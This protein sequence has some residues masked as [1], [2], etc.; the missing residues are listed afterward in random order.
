MVHN[1]DLAVRDTGRSP[2]GSRPSAQ[3]TGCLLGGEVGDAHGAAVE[4]LPLATIRAQFG[5]RGIQ[6]QAP[7]YGRL[8]A[9]TDDTQLTLFTAEELIRAANRL[10][11]GDRTDRARSLPPRYPTR[12]YARPCHKLGPLPRLVMT[13]DR[14]GH[15]MNDGLVD[16]FRHSTWATRQ[17]LALSQDL[18]EAQ[19]QVTVPGT[20][21]SILDTFWHMVA[22]EAGYYARLTGEEPRWDRRAEQPPSLATLARYVDDLEACWDRFLAQPFDGERTLVVP[23]E[24]GFDRNVPAGVVLAQALHHGNEHRAHICTVL[25]ILGM[26][27]PDLGVWDYAEATDRAPRRAT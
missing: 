20:Y 14:R 3:V 2:R 10:R 24:D 17:L 5:P 23:W 18:D 12:C 4:F 16:A 21:G 22:S 15:R 11:R 25:T 9:I 13:D 8:G 27:I 1:P 7:A 26:T 6:G 19:L